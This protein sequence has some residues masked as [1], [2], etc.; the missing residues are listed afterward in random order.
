MRMRADSLQS[1]LT[2]CDPLDCRPLGSS[3][4]GILQASILEWVAISFSGGIFPN[5]GSNLPGGLQDTEVWVPRTR[6]QSTSLLR[7]LTVLF[8]D[9]A[10]LPMDKGKMLKRPAHFQRAGKNCE[11]GAMR[12]CT[13][14]WQK[15]KCNLAAEK[16]KNCGIFMQWNAIPEWEWMNWYIQ[17]KDYTQHSVQRKKLDIKERCMIPFIQN[18]ETRQMSLGC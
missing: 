14:N 18:S 9:N 8:L 7:C 6:K 17:H 10:L 13:D 11:F 2:L 16:V 4:H 1:C 5:Q 12:Q 15:L 3:V